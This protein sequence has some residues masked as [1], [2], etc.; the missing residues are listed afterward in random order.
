MV[1]EKVHENQKVAGE[2]AAVIEQMAGEI[3]ETA[4][5]NSG[6]SAAS[7]EQIQN[8]HLLQ[9]TL[10]QLF[11]TLSESSTK[12]ETT[13]AIG[14]SL[15]KVTGTLNQLMAGFTFSKIHVIE[16]VQHEKRAYPRTTNR[17]LVQAVQGNRKV[18]CYSLDFS[19][20]G[21]RLEL[22]EKLDDRRLVE[23]FVTLPCD[24]LE[25]YKGQDPLKLQGRIARQRAEGDKILCGIAFEN[26]SEEARSKIR[27]SF[28]YYNKT[29]EF[30]PYPSPA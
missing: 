11:A 20:T 1:V 16:S 6:I 9:E 14:E 29:P 12:V 13:A 30:I 24:D 5:A 8:V 21:M 18:E 10:G 17:L 19:M 15:H 22:N 7:G 25:L 4:S 28:Q 2:T 3:A 26:L 27:A 23:L